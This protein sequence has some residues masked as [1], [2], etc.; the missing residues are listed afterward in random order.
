[1]E[2]Q[3]RAGND[4]VKP[5]SICYSSVIDAYARSG[6]SY[7]GVK[8]VELLDHMISLSELGHH[9]VRPNTRTYCSVITALGRSQV[10]GAAD[11]AER[12]LNDME[13]MYYLYGNSDVA[14]NTIVFNAVIDAW[15]RSSFVF[16]AE[17]ANALLQRM[18]EEF[19]EGN[20]MYKPDIISY[21]SV[22]S[23]AANSF[24]DRNVKNKAFRIA[25]E[26]FKNIQLSK[27][28]SPTSRTYFLFIKAVRKLTV[29]NETREKILKKA[30][31]YC[32]RDQMMNKH[33]LTQLELACR[34]KEDFHTMMSEFGPVTIPISVETI[35]SEWKSHAS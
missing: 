9:D 29:K 12:L 34:S 19:V 26:T 5:D 10:Q 20:I 32:C 14:C 35:P 11:T 30:V 22:I 23:A 24:G 8:A 3:Y 17:K 28:L 2:R 6:E 25:L 13:K 15:S 31:E 33:I 4:D 21:N 16:K 27:D 18:T 1:M 7:A